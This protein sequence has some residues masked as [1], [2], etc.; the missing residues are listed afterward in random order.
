M[1]NNEIAKIKKGLKKDETRA[2]ER[3]KIAGELF[4][5]LTMFKQAGQCFFSGK[6]F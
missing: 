1:N 3:F 2:I 6:L 4:E 5:E